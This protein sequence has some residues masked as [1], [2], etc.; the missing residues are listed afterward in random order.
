M[1]AILSRPQCVKTLDIEMD[2]RKWTLTTQG[3]EL[4]RMKMNESIKREAGVKLA[5]E[6]MQI[7]DASV[8]DF[9]A[10]QERKRWNHHKI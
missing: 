8:F 9:A 7:D 2:R 1:A 4:H 3:L 5:E 10:V 6:H